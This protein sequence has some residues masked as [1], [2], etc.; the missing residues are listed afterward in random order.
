MEVFKTKDKAVE[1]VEI[2]SFKLEKEI[3]ELVEKNTETFFNLEFV[4]S[5][6]PIGE[7]R[8]DTLYFNNETNSFKI[9]NSHIN[10]HI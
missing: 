6:F 5:E 3:Q 8:I 10:T 9:Y 2:Q 7:F 1:Y 4:R